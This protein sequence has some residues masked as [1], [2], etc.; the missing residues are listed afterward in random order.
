MDIFKIIGVL[1]LV[2]ISLGVITQ[3]KESEDL[4]YIVG[5]I[6]LLIYSSYIGDL[7]F[8][9]LQIVFIISAIFH[10]IKVKKTSR[11]K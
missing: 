1:G 10:F 4:I 9:V 7:I 6:L 3:K 5:G 2:M 8:V 11:K